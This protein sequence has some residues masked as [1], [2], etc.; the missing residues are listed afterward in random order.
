MCHASM[1]KPLLEPDKSHRL[2]MKRESCVYVGL[3]LVSGHQIPGMCLV[4]PKPLLGI[5]GGGGE[6]SVRALVS[7]MVS[8]GPLRQ[9]L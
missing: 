3:I 9:E 4:T 6:P 1:T 2:K 7:V 5:T 8:G